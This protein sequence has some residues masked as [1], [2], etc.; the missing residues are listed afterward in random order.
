MYPVSFDAGSA[1]PQ[2]KW[3]LFT[4]AERAA[5]WRVGGSQF[6]AVHQASGALYVVVHQ[7][8]ADSHKDPGM[9]VWVYDIAKQK[10][11]RMIDLASHAASI[12]VT[13]DAAPLLIATTLEVPAVSIY[14][15]ATGE[16]KHVI[17]GGPMTP[18]FTQVR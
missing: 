9:Q 2:P 8:K 12:A 13:S 3:S 17:E 18:S 14:D 10:R 5:G 11:Q 6:N 15:A 16:L 7:G 1:A 4:D